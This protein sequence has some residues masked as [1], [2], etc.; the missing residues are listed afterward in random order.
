MPKTVIPTGRARQSTVNKI[1]LHIFFFI[2]FLRVFRFDISLYVF[3]GKSP[4]DQ[5]HPTPKGVSNK[6]PNQN[7]ALGNP[8]HHMDISHGSIARY[9]Q[10]I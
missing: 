7:V 5:V 3:M 9:F 4:I 10:Q 6:T 2:D 8:V 1:R